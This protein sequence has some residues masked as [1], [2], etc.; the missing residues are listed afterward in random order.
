MKC[1]AVSLIVCVIA[2]CGDSDSS[3]TVRDASVLD[4]DP[5]APDGAIPEPEDVVGPPL[6][7]RPANASCLAKPRPVNPTVQLGNAFPSISASGR[8]V[9]LKQL[10]DSSAHWF[11]AQ[12]DGTLLRFVADPAANSSTVVLDIS[13]RV[14]LDVERGLLGFAFSPSFA[15]DGYIFVSYTTATHSRISRFAS[16]DGGASFVDAA[17]SEVTIFEHVQENANHNGGDIHFGPDGFLYMSLGDDGQS[18]TAQDLGDVRGSILRIDPFGDDNLATDADLTVRD[19]AIPADN[20]FV[21]QVGA[22]PEIYAYGFRNPW[23]FTIDPQNGELWV[24]DVGEADREEVDFVVPGGNYGWPH[25]EGTLCFNTTPCTDSSWIDPI[26]EYDQTVGLSVI[27]GRVYR[28]NTLPQLVGQFIYSEWSTGTVWAVERNPE[29]GEG[30]VTELGALNTFSVVAWGQGNDGEVY[31]A[32]GGIPQLQPAEAP[33]ANPFPALL[34]ET[35]CT[36]S[37]DATQMAE[38]VIPYGV[39]VPLWSDGAYKQ[40]WLAIPDNTSIDI[41]ANGQWELPIGSVLIKEFFVAGERI[42]TRLLM[43]HD[44]NNWAGYPYRWNEQGTDALLV[45]GGASVPVAN[46]NW[47]IPSSPQCLQC[48]TAVAGQTLSPETA[49]LN[50]VYPYEEAGLV[51]QLEAMDQLGLLTS[52]VDNPSAQPALAS[53][54]STSS[55][56]KQARDYLHVQCAHCHQP[57]APNSAFDARWS[58]DFASTG[59]CNTPPLS[60]ELGVTGAMLVTPGDAQT[61]L[62]SL[63]MHAT[64]DKRMPKIGSDIVDLTGT[65]IVDQWINALVGCP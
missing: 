44:D 26:T 50:R 17:V 65:A 9:G 60:G 41:A 49:Q 16:A 53:T 21:A 8:L 24:G 36:T 43:R 20:P 59:W 40:R 12:R 18:A 29:T 46:G 64:D 14:D 2:A 42:E 35:G 62:V 38:G 13:D 39:N 15:T 48:H 54:S 45:L 11:L 28:G 31:A 61:S 56:E 23:R 1:L 25:K 63:R 19:Y 57:G 34:S 52:P 37:G 55:V 27:G 47:T 51:N 4:A 32:G 7:S 10:P 22:R 5:N 33:P 6:G 3:G 30:T 58:V